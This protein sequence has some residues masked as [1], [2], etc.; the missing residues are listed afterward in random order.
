MISR[1]RLVDT[2]TVLKLVIIKVDKGSASHEEEQDCSDEQEDEKFSDDHGVGSE[3]KQGGGTNCARVAE[4][5]HHS[6]NKQQYLLFNCSA[7]FPCPI[8][9]CFSMRSDWKRERPHYGHLCGAL[10][11]LALFHHYPALHHLT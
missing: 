4:F 6:M 8:I 7:T 9:T 1:K 5:A 3:V 2:R 11:A 10:G